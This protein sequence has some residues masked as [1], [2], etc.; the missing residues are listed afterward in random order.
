MQSIVDKAESQDSIPLYL[1]VIG[2]QSIKQSRD[3]AGMSIQP[4]I[5][6]VETLRLTIAKP[7]FTHVAT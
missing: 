3:E 1:T 6:L 5:V 2:P 7:V 4:Q